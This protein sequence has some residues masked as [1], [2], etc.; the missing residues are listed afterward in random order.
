MLNT[1]KP[2]KLESRIVEIEKLLEKTPVW[3][4]VIRNNLR[5]EEE[6][7]L[8]QL[9]RPRVHKEPKQII[10]SPYKVSANHYAHGNIYMAY[11]NSHK[12]MQQF[13]KDKKALLLMQIKEQQKI[14]QLAMAKI[15]ELKG[16]L[17]AVRI[18]KDIHQM[19]K[20][21]NYM[22]KPTK[23]LL[24]KEKQDTSKWKRKNNK[25]NQKITILNC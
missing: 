18:E 9:A 5:I 16:I 8:K 11:P 10:S 4:Y 21:Q 17:E 14:M 19:M 2:D 7:L 22:K 12:D 3:K 24:Q 13:I 20:C 15:N 23:Y 25:H 1:P 6:D